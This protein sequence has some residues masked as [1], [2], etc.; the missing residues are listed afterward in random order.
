MPSFAVWGSF[1]RLEQQRRIRLSVSNFRW[2]HNQDRA[3]AMR[4]M[5]NYDLDRFE[6]LWNA[7]TVQL[8]RNYNVWR[9]QRWYGS[10]KDA[11]CIALFVIKH[12]GQWDFPARI[13]KMKAPTVER[14]VTR[15][16]H[17]NFP[18]MYKEMV[19]TV[20]EEYSIK[21]LK[22]QNQLFTSLPYAF[23]ETLVTCKQS[24]RPSSGLRV[25]KRF[26]SSP[27]T[28]YGFKVEMR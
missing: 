12:G 19:T 22:G 13:F 14:L 5:K 18:Y 2:V 1:G 9:G 26:Y 7:I 27:K 25:G 4:Q 15:F 8:S 23:N 6:D 24:F 11:L 3:E 16:K 17:I 10:D 28:L 20:V 21:R